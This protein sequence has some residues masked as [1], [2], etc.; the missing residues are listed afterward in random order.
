[1]PDLMSRILVVDDEAEIRDIL[2]YLLEKE[3][4]K[5]ITASDGQQAMQKICLET[6]DAVILDVRLPDLDGIELLK[7]IKEIFDDLPI[8]LI[9]G[10]ADVY[11]A[12][13]AMKAGAYDY[14]VKP[15]DNNEVVRIIRHALSERQLKQK[16]R[17]VTDWNENFNLIQSMGLSDKIAN[18][19]ADCQRVAKSEFSIIITGETGSGKELVAQAIHLNSA[20]SKMPFVAVDCG[21]IPETL[22]ESEL[23]GHEKGSFTGAEHQKPGKFELAHGGTLFMDEITNMSLGSQMKFM[24]AVQER[25]FYR[26]GGIKC[27]KMNVRLIVATNRDIQEMVASGTFK[28]DLYYRLNE[29]TINIPPLRERKEDI[30]YLAN[31]FLD[32]ANIE[33]NKLITGFSEN[34]IET[35]MSYN[36]PGNVRQLR[37]VVRQAALMAKNVITQRDLGIKPPSGPGLHFSLKVECA[38]WNYGSLSEIVSRSVLAVERE[39]LTKVMKIT[40][41]NKARAARLL[42]VDYKTIHTKLKKYC[43]CQKGEDN[44]NETQVEP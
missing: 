28:M 44:D 40:G 26:V 38:P 25:M 5:V 39:V 12:V 8:V 14:L 21:A 37:S 7:K 34:A 11:Q 31:R 23:F 32:G 19:T 35:L 36:W 6:P 1:M 13:D 33:L 15:F 3:G 10:H 18:L 17:A 4:F 20:R 29:F 41:G 16:L 42:H 22:M 43:I 9:T 27:V 30:P 24:R 2:V